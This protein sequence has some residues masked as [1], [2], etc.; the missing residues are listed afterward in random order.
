MPRALTIGLRSNTVLDDIYHASALAAVRD[1]AG[2][3]EYAVHILTPR[4]DTDRVHR[5]LT[6][7]GLPAET[8]TDADRQFWNETTSVL[9]TSSV[10]Q[11]DVRIGRGIALYQGDW[12]ATL[13]QLAAFS[14]RKPRR[15]LS[16]FDGVIH[17]RQGWQDGR[18]QEAVAG[19]PQALRSLLGAGHAVHISTQRPIAQLPD[20]ARWLA[21]RG[22]PAQASTDAGV[23][24]T[25]GTVLV[26]SGVLPA[27]MEIENRAI[28]LTGDNWAPVLDEVRQRRAAL[29]AYLAKRDA[30]P[31]PPHRPVQP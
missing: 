1:L 4:Q 6:V 14:D 21:D 28:Q 19:A 25:T 12:D 24:E 10:V 11:G 5:L 13:R 23:W 2:H 16:R 27:D 30:A 9:V 29:L 18:L 17:D 26:T 3:P 20:I 8:N 31:R 7:H 15:I 22:V